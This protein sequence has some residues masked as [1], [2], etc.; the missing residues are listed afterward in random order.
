MTA[1]N[2]GHNSQDAPATSFAKDQLKAI[3]ERIELVEVDMKERSQDRK[4][5][6]LEAKSAGFDIPSIRA[7]V[8]MRK[9]D[10]NKRA[11]REAM[12][13]LYKD[14]LGIV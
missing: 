10:A 9:E 6:Y 12:I 3:I 11:E 1:P 13:E 14:N 2:I 5:I 7:I 8:R 4:E